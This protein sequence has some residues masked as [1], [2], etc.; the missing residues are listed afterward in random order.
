MNPALRLRDRDKLRAK[1]REK[2]LEFLSRFN[3]VLKQIQ[4]RDAGKKVTPTRNHGRK[5]V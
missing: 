5:T 1:S 3:A 2:L 4:A